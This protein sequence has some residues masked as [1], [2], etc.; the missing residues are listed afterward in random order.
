MAKYTVELSLR[1]SD[2]VEVEADSFFD[3][4]NR[5]IKSLPPKWRAEFVSDG[6]TDK[7]VFGPCESCG[8]PLIEGDDYVWDEDGIRWHKQCPTV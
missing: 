3:A 8:L 7:E 1:D 4:A 6:E 2:S 5:V